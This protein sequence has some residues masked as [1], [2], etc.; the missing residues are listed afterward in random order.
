MT[1]KQQR[2]SRIVWFEI[3][4]ADFDR[5]IRFYEN[6][7]QMKL[8]RGPFGPTELAI[9]PY[10]E[11]AISGTITP[12]EDSPTVGRDG[13]VVY[14]NADPSLDAVLERVPTAGGSVLQGRTE[15]P[16]GMGCFAKI[17][18]SEGNTIGLHALS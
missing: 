6:I 2:E 5:A 14:L 13:V 1:P 17:A 8:Q 12:P 4:S 3:P 10:H 11:P 7:L 16:P 18:D 15:L 9:F